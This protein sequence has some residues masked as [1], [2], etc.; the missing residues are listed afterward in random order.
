[1][2][3]KSD[4]QDRGEDLIDNVMKETRKHVLTKC[5]TW[6]REE[7]LSNAAF[8]EHAVEDTI[9]LKNRAELKDKER[10]LQECRVALAKVF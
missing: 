6:V 7:I 8:L 5:E 2:H 10:K 4:L 3:C 1:M 9:I